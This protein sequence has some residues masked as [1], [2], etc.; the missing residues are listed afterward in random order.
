M[1]P[2][3]IKVCELMR[4]IMCST[5]SHTQRAIFRQGL[6]MIPL[7]TGGFHRLATSPLKF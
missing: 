3:Y 5:F 1:T 7:K 6:E 4:E 2:F